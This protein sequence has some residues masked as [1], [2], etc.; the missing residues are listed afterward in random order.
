MIE[1]ICSNCQTG[2]TL[3]A[4]HCVACGA[5]LD[6]PLARRPGAVLARWSS[7]VPVRWQR[8]GK[9]MALG[10]AALAVEVGAAWLQRRAN[11]RPAPIVRYEG[12]DRGSLRPRFV[13]RQRV[14]E[15]YEGGQISRRVIEQTVWRLPDE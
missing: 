3:E 6:Q 8:A 10:A 2:N 9:A 15:T 11:A 12:A 13:A 14:W 5:A 7:G 4:E 1:R